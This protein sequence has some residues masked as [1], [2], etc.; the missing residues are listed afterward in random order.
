MWLWLLILVMSG[1]GGVMCVNISILYVIAFLLIVVI[2]RVART[3]II[4][5]LHNKDMADE[6][7]HLAKE[8][9]SVS[10]I[11]YPLPKEEI[12]HH[13]KTIPHFSLPMIPSSLICLSE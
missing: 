4:G 7:H 9:R 1:H 8:C 2:N 6:V 3:V 5:G 10:S 13:G 12:T 11:T